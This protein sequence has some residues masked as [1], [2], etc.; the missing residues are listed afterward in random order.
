MNINPINMNTNFM[1]M[2]S[3]VINMNAHF[4]RKP[5]SMND[6]QILCQIGKGY[7]G[8][9]YKVKYNINGQIYALKRYEKAKAKKEHEIDYYREKTILYDLTRR[10]YPTIVKLYADFEDNTTKNLVMEYVEGITLRKKRGNNNGYVP[11]NEVIN[12]LS[13][14]LQTIDF[15]HTKCRIIHR[16]IKPDNIMIQLNNQIKLL[17][18]GISVYIENP[19]NLL[20]CHKSVKGEL[21][22][23]PPEMIFSGF[24]LNYDQRMD[25]FS[26]GFTMY[27]FMNPS[28]N[29]DEIN[30]P[31]IT[32]K[33]NKSITR[34][35]VYIKNTAYEPWLIDFVESLYCKDQNKRP[36]AA[37][38]LN[39]LQ[40]FQTNP[41]CTHIFNNLKNKNREN[42]INNMNV[43]FSRRDSSNV[44]NNIHKF[45]TSVPNQ[46][47]SSAQQINNFPNTAMPIQRMNTSIVPTLNR[48]EPIF[49]TNDMGQEISI[50][51]SMK[52]LLQVL[53]HLDGMSFIQAQILSLFIDTRIDYS[54]YF[55]H[56]FQ[57][58]LNNVHPKNCNQIQINQ[59]YY[60]QIVN[61]FIRKVFIYNNSGI[62]GTRPIILFYMI[63]SIIKE[64]F[65]QYFNSYQNKL[66]DYIIY[67]NFIPLNNII[68]MTTNPKIYNQISK[69]I[70]EFKNNFKGP[71]VDNFYFFILIV[72]RCSICNNILGIRTRAVQFL[73]LDVPNPQNNITDL[74]NNYFS[75]NVTENKY[76]DNCKLNRQKMKRLYCLN[77]PNYLILEL[78]DKNSVNFNSNI[79]L[80][81]FDGTMCSYQYESCIYKLKINNITDFV[82]VF[83]SG[84]NYFFYSDDKIV[85]YN[86][87]YMNLQCPSLAIYQK[88]S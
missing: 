21:H 75:N 73:Q 34:K 23:V 59:V 15:L 57:Q 9:V 5:I 43:L 87:A 14:L 32:E 24:P 56:S 58:M 41:N 53:Y 45:N 62:S 65:L 18:F 7:F 50:L 6:F 10:G 88:I 26:L 76:C 27:S 85:P 83:R 80:P 54:K 79:M 64:N 74:I 31:Q 42:N 70:Y 60:T 40:Q 51:S 81:L 1:N 22:Y 12:I 4:F 49:L 67:N 61:D 47:S 84:N 72:S 28:N 44:I 36:M 20:A 35:D 66:L 82:A 8:A 19:D 46:M 2:N 71:L 38:A 78:E 39:L 3:N 16:D 52:S 77:L 69:L 68:P 11:Q 17:D 63:T 30:L 37:E 33:K 29:E 86:Q 48:V 55:I 13:Q 25:I